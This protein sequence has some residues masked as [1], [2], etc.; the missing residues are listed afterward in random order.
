[1]RRAEL[2]SSQRAEF[3]EATGSVDPWP[4]LPSSQADSE[5]LD[6]VALAWE[7]HAR[8]EELKRDQTARLWN[9]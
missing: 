8:L 4:E 3:R 5:L 1:L 9:G 2:A 7:R 6:S